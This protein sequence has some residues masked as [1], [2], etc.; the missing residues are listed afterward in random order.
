L[1]TSKFFGQDMAIVFLDL[2]NP[3]V[4]FANLF[5]C[6]QVGKIRWNKKALVA[7]CFPLKIL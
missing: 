4:G 2:K 1:A 7:I 6:H 3:F 5:F